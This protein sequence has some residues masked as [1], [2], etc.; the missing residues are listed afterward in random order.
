[1]RSERPIALLHSYLSDREGKERP[2]RL[3]R[4]GILAAAELYRRGDIDKIC[5]TVEPGLSG[6]QARRLKILLNDPP[7]EGIVVEA[8][9]V[10]TEE[11]IK[12]FKKLAEENGWNSLITIGNPAHLPRIKREIQRTFKSNPVEAKSSREIL[13]QHSRYSSILS[14]MKDWPEQ[15]SLALQEKI[16]NL[17]ILGSL[18]LKMAPRLAH[19]KVTLQTW[20]Y[21]QI[22]KISSNFVY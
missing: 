15:K 6:P 4:V 9:T 7:E 13:S 11:E 22:E 17:P 1:M 20:G 8:K 21:R 5:I 16:L 2:D 10:T 19:L 3:S 12:T 18:A 14:D